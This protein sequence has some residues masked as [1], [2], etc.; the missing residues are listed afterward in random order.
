MRQATV[1]RRL[2]ARFVRRALLEHDDA[3]A[4]AQW[5]HDGGFSVD[6]SV[7]I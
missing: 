2:L 6:G 5:V 1:R 7:R 3:Q 4:M